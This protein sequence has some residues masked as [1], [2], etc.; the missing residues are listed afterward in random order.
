MRRIAILLIVLALIAAACGDDEGSVLGEPGTT[1]APTETSGGDAVTTTV[2]EAAPAT[3]EAAPN[4]PSGDVQAALLN[5]ET[6][7]FRAVYRFG[8][9]DDEQIIAISRDPNLDPPASATLIG[10]GGEE[11]RFLT[12]GD[13]TII[14]GPPGEDCIEFPPE[15]GMD[16]GQA[17]LGPVLS[18]FLLNADIESTPGFT[19]EEDAATIGGRR[20]LCF[21]YTP[22]ALAA[23]ADVAFMRQ[24]VDA[25]LGFILLIETL[26]AGGSAVETIIELLEFGLPTPADFEPSGPLTT[27]PGG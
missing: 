25:E 22:T 24:C 13:R 7:T 20:G 12:I 27:M 19:V 9:G 10:P 2:P 23:G 26:E 6:A 18:G 17:L 11:A 15:L 14:C 16:M 5:Y 3:T 1:S 21:T 4:A 8:E